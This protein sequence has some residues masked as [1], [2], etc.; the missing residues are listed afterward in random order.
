MFLFNIL[1]NRCGCSWPNHTLALPSSA[2]MKNENIIFYSAHSSLQQIKHPQRAHTLTHVWSFLAV[3]NKHNIYKG[4]YAYAHTQKSCAQTGNQNQN[5][6]QN[7]NNSEMLEASVRHVSRGLALVN[8]WLQ[9]VSCC[10]SLLLH[11]KF[12][13][14]TQNAPEN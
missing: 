6:N 11:L 3:A 5:R 1:A 4:L 14:C 10:I 8:G 2:H 7:Q 12:S 13:S 9:L